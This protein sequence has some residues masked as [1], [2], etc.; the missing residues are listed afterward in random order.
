[1]VKDDLSR[2]H[3]QVQGLI[4]AVEAEKQKGQSLK[5]SIDAQKAEL[6][7]TIAELQQLNKMHHTLA[8]CNIRLNGTL[9]SCR[10]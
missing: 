7:N 6:K 1:M 4:K 3:K 2:S 10:L 9:K 8:P 5:A